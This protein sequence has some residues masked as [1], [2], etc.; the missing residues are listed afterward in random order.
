[1]QNMKTPTKHITTPDA[2]ST[3][4]RF[5]DTKKYQNIG[6]IIVLCFFGIFGIWSAFAPLDEAVVVTGKVIVETN[7]KTV[8]HLEGGIID[9]ILVKNGDKVEKGQALLNISKYQPEADLDVATLQL[10]DAKILK[11]RLNAELKKQS[12]LV[13]SDEIILLLKN[14]INAEVLAEVQSEIFDSRREVIASEVDVIKQRISQLHEQIGGL[15]LLS[16][17]KLE[18]SDLYQQ[19]I[20]EWQTLYE[21]KLVDNKALRE[22]QHKQFQLKGEMAD[23]TAKI[24]QIQV[25]ILE[26]E[27]QI[28]LKENTFRSNIAD[29]LREAE[30]SI[31]EYKSKLKA[32]NNTLSRTIIKSPDHGVVAGLEMHTVGGVIASGEP[33]M[34]IVPSLRRFM[35]EAKVPSQQ[36]EKLALGANVDIRFPSFNGFK[37]VIPGSVSTVSADSFFDEKTNNNYYNVKIKVSIGGVEIMTEEGIELSSGMPTEVIIKTGVRTL[38]DYLLTPFN[39]MAVRSFN[40]Q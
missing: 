38:L 30:F 40:E 14:N 17:I 18:K 1:M 34:Y 29:D 12:Q 26:E 24:A 23:L 10:W 9:K 35:I 28:L 7:R 6:L 20:S 36:S 33:I 5:N 16:Q 22:T 19:E 27:E 39:D 21:Q 4:S 32:L 25:Q 3:A 2:N 37:G 11:E 15:Q 8:Q 31:S 13:Y